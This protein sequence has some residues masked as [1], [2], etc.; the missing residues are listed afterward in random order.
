MQTLSLLSVTNYSPRLSSL[1]LTHGIN[2]EC[3]M[4]NWVTLTFLKTFFVN[5]KGVIKLNYYWSYPKKLKQNKTKIK[6]LPGCLNEG[7]MG[8]KEVVEQVNNTTLLMVMYI[9][10]FMLQVL[11]KLKIF[12]IDFL[13]AKSLFTETNCRSQTPIPL[14]VQHMTNYFPLIVIVLLF[15]L[16]NCC[17]WKPL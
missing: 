14:S 7:N 6:T 12:E 1:F 4:I 10:V 9:S 5:R 13:D 8:N 16:R 11:K 15:F 2:T 17:L 3:L